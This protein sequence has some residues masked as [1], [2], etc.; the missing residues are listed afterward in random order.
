MATVKMVGTHIPY[1]KKK[2]IYLTA[3]LEM[4]RA[5]QGHNKIGRLAPTSIEHS[6]AS[7]GFPRI[8]PSGSDQDPPAT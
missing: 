5:A 4:P 8:A 2:L 6:L 1:Q 3:V 7:A